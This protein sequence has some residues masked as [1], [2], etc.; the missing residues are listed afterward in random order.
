MTKGPEQTCAAGPFMPPGL[1]WKDQK[2]GAEPWLSGAQ[3]CGS[4]P[5]SGGP[6]TWA[7]EGTDVGGGS[8]L[9]HFHLL[10]PQPTCSV[11]EG[12]DRQGA[13][14]PQA[15]LAGPPGWTLGVEI[16]ASQEFPRS[17]EAW[18]PPSPKLTHP[19][20]S[21]F[22]E[23]SRSASGQPRNREGSRSPMGPRVCA[24]L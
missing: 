16:A 1:P 21:S 3:R 5:G 19:A 13:L 14:C 24:S 11:G 22:K 18:A 7:T 10:L 20:S 9:S 4:D 23:A 2:Q 12:T 6:L 15:P 17:P 8:S